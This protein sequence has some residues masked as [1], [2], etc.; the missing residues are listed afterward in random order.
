MKFG[1]VIEDSVSYLHSNLCVYN[2]SAL[3]PPTGHRWTYVC[4]NNSA[5]LHR[6]NASPLF[7]DSLDYECNLNKTCFS[8]FFL[9][10][11][12]WSIKLFDGVTKQEQWFDV[13]PSNL[14]H[15]IQNKC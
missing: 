10:Q 5:M 13:S 1:T 4:N 9:I 15:L 8:I 7:S 11:D 14:V 6:K 3:A 12:S 2:S